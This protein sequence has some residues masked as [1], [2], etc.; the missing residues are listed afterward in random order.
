MMADDNLWPVRPGLLTEAAMAV[1]WFAG[2]GVW[3]RELGIGEE[4]I[5]LWSDR[6]PLL[7]LE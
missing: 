5:S 3:Y 2:S 4:P 7:Y 1:V 6:F